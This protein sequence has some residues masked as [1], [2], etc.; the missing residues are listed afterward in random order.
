MQKMLNFARRIQISYNQ[1]MNQKFTFHMLWAAMLA[2]ALTF[3]SCSG[4]KDAQTLFSEDA[5]GVVVIV[6]RFYYELRLGNGETLYF[7]GLDDNGDISGL[8]ADL[9]EA[10]RNKAESYGTGFFVDDKGLILTNRHVVQPVIDKQ[11]VQRAWSSIIEA[12][13]QLCESYAQQLSDQFDQLESQ[14]S[15]CY[16]YDEFTG[17]YVTD[18]VRLSQIQSQQEQLRQEYQQAGSAYH[19]LSDVSVNSVTVNSVCELG[20]AYNDTYASSAADF[21]NNNPC[22]VVRLSGNDDVDLAL[23]QLKSRST[24]S[25]AHIFATAAH[26]H[27]QGLLSSLFGGGGDAKLTISQ[28][29]YMIGYN[30]GPILAN[31]KQGIKVQMTTGK[32]TQLPDG[33]RLLYDIPTLQGSSGSPV[34]DSYG[35]L[36]AVNYAKLIGS[37]N[38]NFGIPVNKIE[39]F[40][41]D[42]Q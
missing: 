4:E 6:N 40:L 38:F 5:S 27:D 18:D 32:V 1:A 42:K 12:Y 26:R 11:Q 34:I 2:L 33:D 20:I 9:D 29:L 22:S 35:N 15:D 24:P 41:Y 25:G 21:L 37:D 36:V 14:K 7:T 10:K 16:V 30:A 28:P 39:S 31:T 23:I 3:A 8:T 17:S 19:D 13:K